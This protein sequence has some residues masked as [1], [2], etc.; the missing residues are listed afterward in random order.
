MNRLCPF[1]HFLANLAEELVFQRLNP[2]FGV[3]HECLFLLEFRC[4]EAFGIPQC[5]LADVV[6]RHH[7]QIRLRYIDVIAEDLVVSDFQ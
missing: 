7:V 3:Q 2:V 6:G 1:R 4:N 5:L